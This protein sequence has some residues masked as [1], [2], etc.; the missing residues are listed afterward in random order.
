MKLSH[1][2]LVTLTASLLCVG[3]AAGQD[4]K[5]KNADA[6]GT[7]E[8]EVSYFLP[9]AYGSHQR[10]YQGN[11][12]GPTH[13]SSYSRYCFDFSP[14]PEGSPV[15]AAAAGTV[16]YVKQDT[17]GP[18]GNFEDNNEVA[19][20]HAD[21]TVGQYLHLQRLGARVAVGD[22]VLAGDLIGLSGNT[23]HSGAPHLCFGLRDKHRF[24]GD[25]VPCRFAD[26]S[27]GGVPKTNDNVV[28]RNFPIRE[29]VGELAALEKVVRLAKAT[30]GLSALQDKYRT[31]IRQGYPRQVKVLIAK[32][33]KYRP[34]LASVYERERKR[35]LKQLE[36]HFSTSPSTVQTKLSIADARYQR[37]LK[38]ALLLDLRTQPATR[39]ISSGV[40]KKILREYERAR[41]LCSEES[42]SAALDIHIAKL[43]LE[44]GPK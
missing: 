2:A 31:T 36:G 33:K 18:T 39:G 11:N 41:K 14:L 29:L 43:R 9:F 7:P 17:Q 26:V 16:V 28:S 44:T 22:R 38:K 30:N 25:S 6:S 35:L 21:G 34:D 42:A 15:H 12:Q 1:L 27:D 20:Q 3:N 32:H 19:I 10:V 13:N 40:A 5:A 8:A 37:Q 23:G 24:F 4:E